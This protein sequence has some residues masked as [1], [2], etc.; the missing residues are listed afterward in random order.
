MTDGFALLLYAAPFVLIW[1]WYARK[2]QR[3]HALSIATL[4][5]SVAAGLTEPASLH[6]VVDVNKCI[7]CGSCIAEWCTERPRW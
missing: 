3:L 1:V 5:D 4:E 7:G 6:P 2:R